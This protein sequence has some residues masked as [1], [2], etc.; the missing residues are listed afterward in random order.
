MGEEIRAKVRDHP[1][2]EGHHEVVSRAGRQRE[3]RNDTDH[4]QKISSDEAGVGIGETKVDHAPHRDRHDE[5]RGGSDGERDQRQ[6]DPTAM[7]EGVRRERSQGAER[8]TGPFAAHIGGGW[9]C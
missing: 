8:D 7:S 6:R 3:H 9:H 2:A 4:G 5:R 1:F